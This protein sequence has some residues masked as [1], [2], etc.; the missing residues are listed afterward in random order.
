MFKKIDLSK[1]SPIYMVEATIYMFGSDYDLY[2]KWSDG[3]APVGAIK[4]KLANIKTNSLQNGLILSFEAGPVRAADV[5]GVLNQSGSYTDHNVKMM[6]LAFSHS[7]Y[8]SAVTGTGM[9]IPAVEKKELLACAMAV[10]TDIATNEGALYMI[11]TADGEKS[12]WHND[13]SYYQHAA[14]NV[15]RKRKPVHETEDEAMVLSALEDYFSDL[16]KAW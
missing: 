16:A 8:F 13:E 6:D 4:N 12:C 10:F 3:N 9:P 11:V 5:C 2:K 15:Q 1:G 14:T 7:I